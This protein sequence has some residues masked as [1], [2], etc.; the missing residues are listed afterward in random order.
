MALHLVNTYGAFGS[1]TKARYE[2]V[3]ES[4]DED[5]VREQT[6]WQEYEFK[7]KPGDN[8]RSLRLERCAKRIMLRLLFRTLSSNP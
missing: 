7:A 8:F 3:I 4:T 2:I 5:A 6:K 1:V